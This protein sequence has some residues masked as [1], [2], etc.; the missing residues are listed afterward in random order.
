[1]K[2]AVL[3]A[4]ASVAGVVQLGVVGESASVKRGG[5][6]GYECQWCAAFKNVSSS[7]LPW[8]RLALYLCKYDQIV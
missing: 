2:Y 8:V 7:M 4:G 6:H 5:T 3:G 1:M